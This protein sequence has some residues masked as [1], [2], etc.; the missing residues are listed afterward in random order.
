MRTALQT[1]E[2]YFAAFNAHDADALLA[3]LHPHVIHDINEG[4]Q[5]V[6][7]QAFRAF[8]AHMDRCYREHISDLVLLTNPE[9]P[10]RVAAEFTCSGTYLATDG[11]LPPATGQTYAIPAAA[12]FD[13]EE[14]QVT[15]VTSYYNLKG[16]IAAVAPTMN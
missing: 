5:E 8:K 12:F 2:T 10:N 6:G 13:V 11:D 9:Y 16:W 4:G 7:I 1:V 15:R 14:G 3:T